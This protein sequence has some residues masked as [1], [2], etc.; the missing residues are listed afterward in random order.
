MRHLSTYLRMPYTRHGLDSRKP[1]LNYQLSR[2]R[3]MVEC[4]FGICTSKWCVLLTAMH[5]E[6]EHVITVGLAC[7]FLH[8]HLHIRENVYSNSAEQ[9]ANEHGGQMTATR[10]SNHSLQ[11]RDHFADYFLTK[12]GQVSWK[13]HFIYQFFLGFTHVVKFYSTYH[14]FTILSFLFFHFIN[15]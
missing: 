10:P 12:D 11:I 5:Q 6:I 13:N 4:A 1:T 2:E 9:M 8:N 3:R 7:C 15:F 14:C